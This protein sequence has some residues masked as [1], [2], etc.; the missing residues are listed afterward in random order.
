MT[1]FPNNK[2]IQRGGPQYRQHSDRYFHIDEVGWFVRTRGDY[3]T[4]EGMDLCNGILGPFKS[5]AAA[6]YE[7]LKMLYE[8]DPDLFEK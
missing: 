7:L 6:K 4:R 2:H 1:F 8:T 5:K 3:E